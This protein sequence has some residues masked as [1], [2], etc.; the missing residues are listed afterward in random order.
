MFILLKFN[1]IIEG[2]EKMTVIYDQRG[3]S[4]SQLDKH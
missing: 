4:N 3:F 1:F 2:K